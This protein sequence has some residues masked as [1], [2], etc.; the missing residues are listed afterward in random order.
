MRTRKP[1]GAGRLKRLPSPAPCHVNVI[2]SFLFFCNSSDHFRMRG[3]H[4]GWLDGSSSSSEELHESVSWGKI[5]WFCFTHFGHLHGVD[6]RTWSVALQAFGRNRIQH[7][8]CSSIGQE[9][10]TACTRDTGIGDTHAIYLETAFSDLHDPDLI[11]MDLHWARHTLNRTADKW[12][13]RQRFDSERS[14]L[15]LFCSL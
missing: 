12:C 2:P 14:E 9:Y 3:M 7:I 11:P 15:M 5:Y 4:S 6:A 1:I 8:I 13:C 10:D